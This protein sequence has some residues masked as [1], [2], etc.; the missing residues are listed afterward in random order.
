M[1][2]Y[3]KKGDKGKTQLLGG[4]MVDKFNESNVTPII[5]STFSFENLPEALK[6]MKTGKHLGKI[7]IDF[8]MV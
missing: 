2:I 7:V 3:T 4:S 1:K 6:Y 8:D 5:D